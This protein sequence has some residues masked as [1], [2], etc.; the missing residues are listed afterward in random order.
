MQH[1]KA[2]TDK[3]IPCIFQDFHKNLNNLLLIPSY[4]QLENEAP[5]VLQNSLRDKGINFHTVPQVMHC[6][7]LGEREIRMF[8]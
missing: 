1:I 5:M 7:N 3:K 6:R 4:M 2:S 8:K